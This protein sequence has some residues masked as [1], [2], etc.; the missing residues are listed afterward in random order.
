MNV[1]MD[2][3]SWPEIK[4]VLKQPH[5][6]ILPIGSTEEHGAHLPTNVDAACATYI[7]E[8]AAR[9]VAGETDIRVL[10]APTIVYTDVMPAHKKF[11]GTVA[12]KLDT[13]ISLVQDIIEALLDQGFKNIIALSAHLENNS[14]LEVAIRMI[15]ERRPEAS[16]FALGTV[17]GIGF[18]GKPALSKAGWAGVGHALELETAFCLVIQ[19][20][21]VHL[22]RAIIGERYLP[23]SQR[24]IGATGEDK[25]KGVLYCSGVSGDEEAGTHGDPRLANKELGEKSLNAMVSDLADIIIQVVKPAK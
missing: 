10:V 5:A 25:S 14:P 13:F 3:M 12:I 17:A 18:D 11:P 20:H 1:R 9:K 23:L 19:P 2:Q 24:Y 22:E 7:S 16:I 15:K 21:L 4:E 6:V 8:H